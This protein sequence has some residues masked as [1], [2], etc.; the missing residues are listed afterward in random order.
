MGGRSGELGA[1]MDHV[2]RKRGWQYVASG[3]RV[4]GRK[5]EWPS[6]LRFILDLGHDD[7]APVMALAL[8]FRSMPLGGER[9][10]DI[11]NAER[12]ELLTQLGS[13]KVRQMRGDEMVGRELSEASFLHGM[14]GGVSRQAQL[15]V[16]DRCPAERGDALIERFGVE[17][18]RFIEVGN[19]IAALLQRTYQRTVLGSEDPVADLPE[20]VA[21]AGAMPAAAAMPA[22]V[23]GAAPPVRETYP[24]RR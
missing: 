18:N 4:T 5:L 9:F 10:R 14:G 6:Q 8:D 23:G 16:I 24:W 13:F 17:T 3:S 11:F 12:E 7:H 15:L 21:P 2:L 20:V 19:E 1:E 22:V